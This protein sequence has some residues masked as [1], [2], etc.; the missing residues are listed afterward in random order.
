MGSK[1]RRVR[2]PG[3]RPGDP[4]RAEGGADFRDK[5]RQ[6]IFEEAMKEDDLLLRSETGGG[7]CVLIDEVVHIDDLPRD[8]RPSLLARPSQETMSLQPCEGVRGAAARHAGCNF[9]R[10]HRGSDADEDGLRRGEHRPGPPILGG[11]PNDD[12]SGLSDDD[13]PRSEGD[14]RTTRFV[15][16][17]KLMLSEP[18]SRPL[19]EV[20]RIDDVQ[21]G[22]DG[23]QA[24]DI[25][26][27]PLTS[28]ATDETVLT[29]FGTDRDVEARHG[30]GGTGPNRHL[31]ALR[32]DR[33]SSDPDPVADSPGLLHTSRIYHASL[34]E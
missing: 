10:F 19:R 12:R 34:A 13:E 20:L 3:D 16:P 28:P 2:R 14:V 6:W 24:L 8:T 22:R 4:H 30:G 18:G 21:V 29:W 23:R 11:G 9:D 32:Q 27:P 31:E 1:Q 25:G 26:R 5:G 33:D 17:A 7:L 15:H